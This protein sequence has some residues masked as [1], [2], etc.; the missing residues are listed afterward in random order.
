MELNQRLSLY[1]PQFIDNEIG[2]KEQVFSKLKEVFCKIIPSH[3]GESSIGNTDVKDSYTGQTIK[4]RKLS[5]KDPAISM[6]FTDMNGWK[7]EIIDF[8]PDYKDNSFWEFK[9]RVGREV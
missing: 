7:Y 3:G 1:G 8:F 4:C 9:T 5:I 2:E 6:Y